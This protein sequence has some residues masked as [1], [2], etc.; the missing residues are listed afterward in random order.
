MPARCDLGGTSVTPDSEPFLLNP[1]REPLV[2]NPDILSPP[3]GKNGAVW[4]RVKLYKR[5]VPLLTHGVK[6]NVAFPD[7]NQHPDSTWAGG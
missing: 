4:T 1:D 3:V 2:L 7:L 6:I 5:K